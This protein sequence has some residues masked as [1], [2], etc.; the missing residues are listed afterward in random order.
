MYA[1]GGTKH[2][3][4]AGYKDTAENIFRYLQSE[5]AHAVDA[6]TLGRFCDESA[7][8]IEWLEGYGVRISGSGAP[9]KTSYPVG[10]DYLHQSDNE[11][12]EPMASLAGP[13]PRGHR[14]VGKVWQAW[15]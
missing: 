1:G 5:I 15:T 9:H 2:Q 4:D 11:K 7:A 3:K 14:P 12:A 10:D 6:A 13:V 8:N